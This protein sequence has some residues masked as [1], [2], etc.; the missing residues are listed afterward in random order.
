MKIASASAKCAKYGTLMET[1]AVND[2]MPERKSFVTSIDS[3]PT[4]T[5][6]PKPMGISFAFISSDG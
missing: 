4:K 1:L 6:A 2:V 5:D 3:A